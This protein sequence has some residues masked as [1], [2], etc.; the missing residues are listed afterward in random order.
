MKTNVGKTDS[1]LRV[2]LVILL[3]ILYLSGTVAGGMGI[4]LLNL[5][6]IFLVT[7]MVGFCPL[8]RLFRINSC[9]LPHTA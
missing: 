8:Y 6:G 3:A 9:K 1:A 2:G 7:A 4:A 5:G